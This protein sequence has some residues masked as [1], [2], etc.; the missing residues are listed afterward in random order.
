MALNLGSRRSCGTRALMEIW[1][2]I[3]T[4]VV[5]EHL[6]CAI[7][8]LGNAQHKKCEMVKEAVQRSCERDNASEEE[9]SMSD[10]T[11]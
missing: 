1:W 6:E 4:R 3:A 10:N 2:D 8:A 9:S 5:L 11:N 7:W